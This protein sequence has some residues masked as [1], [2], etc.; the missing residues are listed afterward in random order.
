MAPHREKRRNVLAA[1]STAAAVLVVSGPALADAPP[2]APAPSASAPPIPYE[3]T[4][5]ARPPLPPKAEAPSIPWQDQIQIGG[6]A[7]F[8]V[9]TV[10]ADNGS[11]ITYSPTLGF[12]LHARW[13][14][15]SFLRFTAYFIDARHDVP[16]HAGVLSCQ[17]IA[18]GS[19]YVGSIHTFVFGARFQPMLRV[20][21][22]LRTWAS[23][24]IGWGRLEVPQMQVADGSGTFP[25]YPRSDPFVEFP[26]GVG[27]SF[28]VI[29]D[30]LAVEY[31]F[32]GAFISDQGGEAVNPI[33]TV[34][35]AGHTR[36]I[37]G[38]APFAASF[39]N[40]LGLT[41]RL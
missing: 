3:L 31:E 1:L 23:F 30:W 12:G 35:A 37:G 40:T 13:D 18:C 7:V 2:T 19:L 34:D 14:M 21:S 38:F 26:L 8:A 11:G 20:T 28:D 39:T 33:L 6:D 17:P 32:H 10:H 5:P 9:R 4:R 15:L 22:R 29:R 27:L 25:V 24:G 41:L 36:Q 16:K